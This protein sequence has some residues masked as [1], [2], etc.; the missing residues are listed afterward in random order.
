[1]TSVHGAVGEGGEADPVWYTIPVYIKTIWASLEISQIHYANNT[2][3]MKKMR[4]MSY[5][6]MTDKEHR[7][8]FNPNKLA[9]SSFLSKM[10]ITLGILKKTR[11]RIY[12]MHVH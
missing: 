11:Q 1:M 7:R 4:E 9:A 5:E 6:R 12:N 2:G 3:G 10:K 8:Q